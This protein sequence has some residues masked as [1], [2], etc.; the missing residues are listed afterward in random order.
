MH[1]RVLQLMPPHPAPERNFDLSHSGG[2]EPWLPDSLSQDFCS[3]RWKAFLLRFREEIEQIVGDVRERMEAD[4]LAAS[5]IAKRQRASDAR[6]FLH[7]LSARTFR[8]GDETEIGEGASDSGCLGVLEAGD[9]VH[10]A[11]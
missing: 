2:R 6:D 3:S 11:I 5:G 1:T 10:I 8:A 9:G 4:A 7:L